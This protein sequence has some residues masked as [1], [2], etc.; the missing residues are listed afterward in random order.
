M[1]AKKYWCNSRKFSQH[2]VRGTIPSSTLPYKP[3]KKMFLPNHTNTQI[4]PCKYMAHPIYPR[5][6]YD[7]QILNRNILPLPFR[8]KRNGI[9]SGKSVFHRRGKR[10]TMQLMDF[11]GTD[12]LRRLAERQDIPCISIFMTTERTD[13]EQNRI[14]FKN[15]L[16]EAG[17]MLAAE[18]KDCLLYTSDAADE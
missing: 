14:R 5:V 15:L 6:R 1:A 12:D 16:G 3:L 18:N 4:F 13:A 7:K 17:R 11:F 2:F 8:L 9:R 10:R